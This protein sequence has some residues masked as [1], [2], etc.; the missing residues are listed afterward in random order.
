MVVLFLFYFFNFRRSSF[1]P[2]LKSIF[3]LSW[4]LT[5]ILLLLW[6]IILFI[7]KLFGTLVVSLFHKIFIVF[8]RPNIAKLLQ[9]N[10]NMVPNILI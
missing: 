3:S 1:F 8:L 9:E 5:S 7:V 6:C 4:D 2:S 10:V